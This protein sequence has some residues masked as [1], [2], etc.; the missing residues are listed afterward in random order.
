[1]PPDPKS[2]T[3]PDKHEKPAD[4]PEAPRLI[5]VASIAFPAGIRLALPGQRGVKN[6]IAATKPS[7]SEYWSIHFDPRL[8]HHIVAHFKPGPAMDRP[9]ADVLYI[10]EGMVGTWRRAT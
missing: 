5:A 7:A 2:P 6:S 3:P 8:R 1:M 10:P 9:P 4:A